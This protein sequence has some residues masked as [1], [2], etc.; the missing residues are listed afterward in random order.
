[1]TQR[2]E[3]PHQHDITCPPNKHRWLHRQSFVRCR[4]VVGLQTAKQLITFRGPMSQIQPPETHRH[5]HGCARTLT[6][7]RTHALSLSLSHTHTNRNIRTHARTHAR[8]HTHTH[9]H[10]HPYPPP[11]H[12]H[13]YRFVKPTV[14]CVERGALPVKHLLGY[15]NHVICISFR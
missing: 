2:L 11:T 8:T 3:V 6:H 7:A 1:M 5:V 10:T 9:T 12:T 14:A 15:V 4:G 13:L